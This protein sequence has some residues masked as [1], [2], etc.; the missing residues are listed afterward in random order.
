MAGAASELEPARYERAPA[1]ELQRQG[2]VFSFHL[3]VGPGDAAAGANRPDDVALLEVL[4]ADRLHQHDWHRGV[5]GHL[6]RWQSG[7]GL[8]DVRA[9]RGDCRAVH[10]ARDVLSETLAG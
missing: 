8:R 1:F 3:D 7:R 9:R 5:G 2:A 10:P 4:R 6:A